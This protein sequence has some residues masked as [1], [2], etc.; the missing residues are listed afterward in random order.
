MIELDLEENLI[1]DIEEVKEFAK[2]KL[3]KVFNVS[4]NF[5]VEYKSK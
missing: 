3:L 5:V 2:C 1:E 4:E